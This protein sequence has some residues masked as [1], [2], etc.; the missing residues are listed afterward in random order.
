LTEL[1]PNCAMAELAVESMTMVMIATRRREPGVDG[2][3]AVSRSP[4][5]LRPARADPVNDH[6]ESMRARSTKR[7]E[8]E[9]LGEEAN[10]VNGSPSS[11]GRT[12]RLRGQRRRY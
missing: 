12:A 5:R 8:R 3:I 4:E 2:C 11:D 6:W 10:Q 7:L 1:R 9:D